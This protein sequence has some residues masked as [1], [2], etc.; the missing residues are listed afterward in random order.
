MVPQN[1]RFKAHISECDTELCKSEAC[2]LLFC[3]EER[4]RVG[5]NLDKSTD[6]VVDVHVTSQLSGAQ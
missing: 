5:R 3:G 1:L 2:E 4:G 6:E